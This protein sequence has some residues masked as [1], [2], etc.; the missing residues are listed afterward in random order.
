MMKRALNNSAGF[1]LVELLSSLMI[2]ALI[3]AVIASVSAA[4]SNAQSHSDTLTEIIQSGRSGT[5]QLSAKLRKAKLIT[6]A[7][8]NE[9]ALWGN[10]ANNDK[11]INV[12]EI[13]LIQYVPNKQI[14]ERWQITFPDT[15]PP[16]LR[17]ILNKPQ[18]L[19]NLTSIDNVRKLLSR[20]IYL[21][22][23][24]KKT[25]ITDVLDFRILANPTPPMTRLVLM[26]LTV[27]KDKQKITI[28]NAVRLR[29]DMTSSI[30]MENGQYSLQ[31]NQSPTAGSGSNNNDDND[32]DSPNPPFRRPPRRPWLPPIRPF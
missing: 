13:M 7:S 22:Y 3:G 15:L 24:S 9:M 6:A 31:S 27:G 26:R 25:L 20:P 30:I 11:Q 2:I 23:L 21:R 8:T 17:K 16:I 29:A 28:T 4:L 10:D 19:S 14:V 18:Q 32:D 12:D 1:T 5:M